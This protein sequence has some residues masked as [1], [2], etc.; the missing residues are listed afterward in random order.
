MAFFPCPDR[1]LFKDVNISEEKKK[2]KSLAIEF[3]CIKKHQ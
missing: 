1:R 2:K 3:I